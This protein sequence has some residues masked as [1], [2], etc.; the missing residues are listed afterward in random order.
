MSEERISQ[1]ETAYLTRLTQHE[2][3]TM[4]ALQAIRASFEAHLAAQYGLHQGDRI[5]A[6][7]RITRGAPPTP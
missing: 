2:Q 4:T 3:T 7:G 6:T 5:E 1:E